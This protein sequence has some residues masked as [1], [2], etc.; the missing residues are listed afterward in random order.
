MAAAPQEMTLP[1]L[2]ELHLR[3]TGAT[4]GSL[5]V[6]QAS[7]GAVCA[8]GAEFAG[9]RAGLNHARFCLGGGGQAVLFAKNMITKSEPRSRPQWRAVPQ[10][11][12]GRG[13]SHLV[14]RGRRG[15]EVLIK[16]AAARLIGLGGKPL[17]RTRALF[18]R[19]KRRLKAGAEHVISALETL[20]S[21][22]AL[23]PV[24]MPTAKVVRGKDHY[25]A[26]F[27]RRET[28]AQSTCVALNSGQ[29]CCFDC[30]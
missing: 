18:R 26:C 2:T 21:G 3:Y 16:Q 17:R 15:G 5:L 29:G 22:A 19:S 25:S 7:G 13:A 6:Q 27:A 23:R 28:L 30:R 10:N 1:A 24:R 4:E 8:C 12:V 11:R 20:Q 9:A 14:M